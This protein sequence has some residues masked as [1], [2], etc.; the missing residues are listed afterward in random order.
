M[1][2]PPDDTAPHQ[3]PLWGHPYTYENPA[4]GTAHAGRISGGIAIVE[5]IQSADAPH[6]TT[7][8]VFDDATKTML[9]VAF[10]RPEAERFADDVL[11]LFAV[12]MGHG[13]QFAL[14][15]HDTATI[16]RRIGELANSHGITS[17]RLAAQWVANG[18]A[19]LEEN[20]GMSA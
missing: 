16:T 10:S 14:H 18:G 2:T 20:E 3:P 13:P 11:A 1:T 7:W 17:Q 6:L 19:W 4:T 5:V 12:D 15:A 9:G 8:A